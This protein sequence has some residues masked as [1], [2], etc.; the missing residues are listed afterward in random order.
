MVGADQEKKGCA[1]DLTNDEYYM[2]D[3]TSGIAHKRHRSL[4]VI[5]ETD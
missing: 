1:S 3:A 2:R 5:T 4:F